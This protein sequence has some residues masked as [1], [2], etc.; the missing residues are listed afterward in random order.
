MSAAEHMHEFV[1]S[2]HELLPCACGANRSAI[3]TV[4]DAAADDARRLVA[5][6]HYTGCRVRPEPETLELWLCDAPSHVL[7]ELEAIRPGVYVIHND[8]PRALS[9]LLKLVHSVD[10]SALRAQRIEVN[11]IGPTHDGYIEVGVGTDTAGARAWFEAEY[12][13]GLFRFVIAEPVGLHGASR[14]NVEPA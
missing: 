4:L 1:W 12:G 8:A 11:R 5:E 3:Q 6:A 7:Q 13:S 10:L 2:G 9:E 14:G